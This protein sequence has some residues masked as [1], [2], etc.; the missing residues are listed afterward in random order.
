MEM[1]AKMTGDS[2]VKNQTTVEQPFFEIKA[3]DG[4]RM[5]Y[6]QDSVKNLM[7]NSIVRYNDPRALEVNFFTVI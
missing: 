4:S 6:R 3:A 7:N 2:D 1:M 5:I